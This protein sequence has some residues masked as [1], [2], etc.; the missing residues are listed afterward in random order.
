MDFRKS[1]VCYCSGKKVI[2][3]LLKVQWIPTKKCQVKMKYCPK[4]IHIKRDGGV[5]NVINAFLE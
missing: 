3:H 2:D 1:H 4:N 5:N